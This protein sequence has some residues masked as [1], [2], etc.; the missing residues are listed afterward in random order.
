MNMVNKKRALQIAQKNAKQAYSDLSVYT[1]EIKLDE[2]KWYIDYRLKDKNLDGG[3]P[4]YIISVK[5]GEIL[6]IRYE[7]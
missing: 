5:T 2:D 4:H 7:Q 3:G 1:V 6:S